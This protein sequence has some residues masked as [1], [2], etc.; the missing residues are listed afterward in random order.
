MKGSN[1]VAVNIQAHSGY[2]Y[3]N[4]IFTNRGTITGLNEASSTNNEL[5]KQVV[6]MIHKMLG[7]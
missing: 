3:A 5:G 4:S 1:V 2:Q 7:E 6:A